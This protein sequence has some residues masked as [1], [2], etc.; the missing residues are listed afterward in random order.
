MSCVDSSL[1]SVSYHSTRNGS[2]RIL[3]NGSWHILPS[4]A[5][6]IPP[7][8][9]ERRRVGDLWSGMR[10]LGGEVRPPTAISILVTNV[11]PLFA[12]PVIA[13]S[14]RLGKHGLPNSR[15]RN[16]IGSSS[17]SGVILNCSNN[18][19][20]GLSTVSSPACASSASNWLFTFSFITSFIGY[21]FERKD[22]KNT[23]LR[24]E[25][26]CRGKTW[27]K[28]ES[29]GENVREKFGL[30]SICFRIIVYLCI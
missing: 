5:S 7:R 30:K 12:L 19:I 17:F 3:L 8:P 18:S 22:T 11:L 28:S 10:G 15:N 23:G 29:V 13:T 14:S 9:S 26:M 2:S 6:G 25:K 27:G 24:Q 20:C 4:L 21:S 1:C 16:S